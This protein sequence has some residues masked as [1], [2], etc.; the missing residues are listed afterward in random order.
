M[1]TKMNNISCDGFFVSIHMAGNIDLAMDITSKWV[2]K[3]ACV[4]FTRAEYI[5]TGGRELGFVA[6][7]INYPRFPKPFGVVFDDAVELANILVDELGQMSY[8]IETPN[9]NTMYYR[10]GKI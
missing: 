8:T 5:Y 3:G 2:L 1:K 7:F 10:D 4:Q 9:S 6:R